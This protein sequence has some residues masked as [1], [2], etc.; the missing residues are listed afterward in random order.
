M[1]D[2]TSLDDLRAANPG[3]GFAVYAYTPGGPVTLE[4]LLPSGETYTFLGETMAEAIARAFPPPPE[5]EPE[6]IFD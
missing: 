5:P 1:S 2:Q 3:L 4:V 6:S